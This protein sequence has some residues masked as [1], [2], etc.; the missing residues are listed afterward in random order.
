MKNKEERIPLYLAS[1]EPPPP[2]LLYGNQDIPL[3]GS[4]ARQ[5]L[6]DLE[7]WETVTFAYV[8]SVN[9]SSPSFIPIK[10]EDAHLQIQ[11]FKYVIKQE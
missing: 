6:S 11:D 1:N 9:E 2:F 3:S 8:T 7:N 4:V 5:Y 10:K